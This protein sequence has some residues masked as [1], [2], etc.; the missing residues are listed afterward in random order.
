M[1]SR[2]L[3]YGLPDIPDAGMPLAEWLKQMPDATRK[4]MVV[5]IESFKHDLGEPLG[6]V[7]PYREKPKSNR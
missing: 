1:I 6:M 5:G 3:D 7:Y 4:A 2:R